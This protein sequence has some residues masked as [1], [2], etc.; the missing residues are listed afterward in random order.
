[1]AGH[2]STILDTQR[3]TVDSLSQEVGKESTARFRTPVVR[4]RDVFTNFYET[5]SQFC[6]RRTT[7]LMPEV[8]LLVPQYRMRAMAMIFEHGME[9]SG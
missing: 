2:G 9:A 7:S 3:R 8:F 4:V 1:M 6:L 5:G